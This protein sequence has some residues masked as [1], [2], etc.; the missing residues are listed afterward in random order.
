M[1]LPQPKPG[2]E[3]RKFMKRFLKDNE[4]KKKFPKIKQR[5]AVGAENWR[6]K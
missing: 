3:Y 1:P 2:E 5:F 4:A 6:N